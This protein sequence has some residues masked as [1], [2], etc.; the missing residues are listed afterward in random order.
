MG[1]HIRNV[2]GGIDV[3]SGIG[4]DNLAIVLC[5]Y[6]SEHAAWPENDPETDNGWGEWVEKRPTKRWN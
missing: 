6:F 2:V 1:E 4:S 5:T 3:E